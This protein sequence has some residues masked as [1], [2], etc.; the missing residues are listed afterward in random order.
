[1][2]ICSSIQNVGPKFF[3]KFKRTSMIE[4]AELKTTRKLG[5]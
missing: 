2:G 4:G 1:M 5:K 3:K